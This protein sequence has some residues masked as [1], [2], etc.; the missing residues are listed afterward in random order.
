M[1]KRRAELEN[2]ISIINKQIETHKS[3]FAEIVMKNGFQNVSE[4]Y[5][6]LYASREAWENHLKEQ[7]V[8][9]TKKEYFSNVT[10]YDFQNQNRNT[11]IIRENKKSKIKHQLAHKKS[12]LVFLIKMTKLDL[13][14]K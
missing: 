13:T 6:R 1:K 2:K 14:L 7:K 12:N 3:E 8:K 11:E 4:F 9:N 5:K 10:I